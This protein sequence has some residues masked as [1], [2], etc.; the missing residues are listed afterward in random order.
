MQRIGDRITE[1]LKQTGH[2]QKELSRK[3]GVTEA[4]MSRYL[5][6]QREPKMEIIANLAQVLNTTTD[7]LI[8][9]R[10]SQ[11]KF[12]DTYWMLARRSQTMNRDQKLELIKLLL[13]DC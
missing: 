2:T 6:N 9:G 13:K 12:E 11:E 4:A 8:S 3:V 5:N 1:L 10:S 7:Y